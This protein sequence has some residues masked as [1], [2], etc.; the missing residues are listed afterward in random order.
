M[1]SFASV[2]CGLTSSCSTQIVNGL[3]VQGHLL[4]AGVAYVPACVKV[5]YTSYVKKKKLFQGFSAVADL[6]TFVIQR[7]RE[8]KIKL[9]I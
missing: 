6:G 5:Y 1:F 9:S 2:C 8:S 4:V 3:V 7:F